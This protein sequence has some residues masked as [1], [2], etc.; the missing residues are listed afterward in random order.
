MVLDTGGH[1]HFEFQAEK[2]YI[3]PLLTVDYV[4]M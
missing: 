4:S 2:S 3:F 1:R